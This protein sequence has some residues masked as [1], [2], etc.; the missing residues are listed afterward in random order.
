MTCPPGH[1]NTTS[2][3]MMIGLYE[4]AVSKLLRSVSGFYQTARYRISDN[5]YQFQEKGIAERTD[6]EEGLC[7][8]NNTERADI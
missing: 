3:V 7:L 2:A 1:A 4:R 5:D 8:L 6:Y